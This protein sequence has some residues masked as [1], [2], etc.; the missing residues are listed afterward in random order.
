M[1]LPALRSCYV[2]S[3]SGDDVNTEVILSAA[4]C[5][6]H[7]WHVLVRFVREKCYEMA[8][9]AF[10]TCVQVVFDKRYFMRI[11]PHTE[12]PHAVEYLYGG[13]QPNSGLQ[14]RYN[15]VMFKVSL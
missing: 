8:M 15:K 2:H 13:P 11:L 6:N 14:E 10:I 3:C 1:A 12:I 9:S 7:F 5:E 4:N